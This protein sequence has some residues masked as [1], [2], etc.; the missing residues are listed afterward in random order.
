MSFLILIPMSWAYSKKGFNFQQ[1]NKDGIHI[2]QL[3][4]APIHTAKKLEVPDNIILLF[5]PPRSQRLLAA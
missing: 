4:N 1:D 5:Q 2:I 3:D